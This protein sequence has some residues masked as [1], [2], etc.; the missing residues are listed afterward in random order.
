MNKKYQNKKWRKA[1]DDAEI[2]GR[3]WFYDLR[4]TFYT[5]ALLDAREPV[6]HVSE[7]GGTSI[8]TLQKR[9]LHSDAKKTASVSKAVNF[10]FGEE[11]E[12]FKITNRSPIGS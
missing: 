9:Y 4:H 5:T 7:F 1:C 11:D 2:I 8:K 6:Q 12:N 10:K 3:A